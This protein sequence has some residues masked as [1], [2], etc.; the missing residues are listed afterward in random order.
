MTHEG[1]PTVPTS[2]SINM[3]TLLA[4]IRDHTWKGATEPPEI[5]GYFYVIEVSV[6]EEGHSGGM[7]IL[8]L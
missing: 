8:Q 3:R 1:R 7:K 5:K 6:A 4:Q 2:M